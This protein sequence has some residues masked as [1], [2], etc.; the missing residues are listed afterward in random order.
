MLGN[1]MLQDALGVIDQI[2]TVF[3]SNI[4]I[5]IA[6]CGEIDGNN[7]RLLYQAHINVLD[8]CEKEFVLGE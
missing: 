5:T 3:R 2:R 4:N 6:H 8:I 1:R 7:A